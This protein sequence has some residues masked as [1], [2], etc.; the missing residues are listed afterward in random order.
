[1]KKLFLIIPVFSFLLSSC[2]MYKD[3]VVEQVVNLQIISFNQE[4]AEFDLELLVDNPN[5]YKISLTKSHV[6][7]FFEGKALGEVQ[8][9]EK[10]VIPKK[11]HSTIVLKC[12]AQ[13]E[14][15]QELMGSM[16]TLLFKSTYTLEGK[17]HIRGKALIVSKKVPVEF[18]HK[19]SKRDMGF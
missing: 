18:N 10:I 4:G 1:M 11:S 6:Q 17:G 9:K 16:L 19:I 8:L 2:D 13:F 7:L 12:T 15:F 3:V 14:N 5:N